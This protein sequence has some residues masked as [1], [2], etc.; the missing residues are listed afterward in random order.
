MSD[1]LRINEGALDKLQALCDRLDCENAP[2][3]DPSRK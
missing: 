1:T 2:I 3:N